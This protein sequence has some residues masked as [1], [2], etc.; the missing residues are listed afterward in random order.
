MAGHCTQESL[1]HPYH[2]LQGG[3]VPVLLLFFAG[4]E[5]GKGGGEGG[6]L[7]MPMNK[8]WFDDGASWKSYGTAVI[9][10]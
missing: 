5:V 10:V 7:F 2:L 1:N 3:Q 6:L 9:I 8:Q 4:L